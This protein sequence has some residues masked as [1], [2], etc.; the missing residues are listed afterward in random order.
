MNHKSYLVEQNFNL[1]KN[2]IILF[3]GENNGLKKDLKE[4]IKYGNGKSEILKYFQEDVLKNE[5]NFFNEINNISLFDEKKVY[6]IEQV[7]DKILE[8]I[9]NIEV[10]ID[11]Q[12]IYLF[13]DSLDKKSKI[14]NYFEKSN[15]TDVV[16]CYADNEISMKKIIFNKLKDF[17]GLSADNINLII[18]SCNLDRAKLNNEL[19]KVITFFQ[20][21]KLERD[22][23]EKLLDTN[24]NADFNLLKD[25]ALN[26]NKT[27]TNKLLSD[28]IMDTE[29]NILYLSIINQRLNKL[30]EATSLTKKTNIEK[31]IDM[32]KPPIFWKD[33][34]IFMMQAKKW[35]MNKIKSILE[36][37]YNLEIKI[38]SDPVIDKNILMK[39][40]LVDICVLANV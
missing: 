28:T 12:K 32:M 35:N 25:E 31:A 1:L 5:E 13:A 9:K 33:K 16:A 26:G 6:I 18:S 39:K 4:K 3:Y 40:L 19:S 15:T 8:L 36:K 20:N 7:N 37:T 2:K 23:L 14:R 30:A 34:P 24:L 38:K 11:H 27:K 22:K 29:K 21:K 10:K 17:A